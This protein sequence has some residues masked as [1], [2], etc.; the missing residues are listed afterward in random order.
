MPHFTFEQPIKQL[1]KRK[2][3]YYY[4][5]I[6]ADIVGKYE[7]KQATRLQCIIDQKVSFSCGLNH[8]GDGNYFIVATRHVK[9]LSKQENDVVTFE[10][11]EDPNPLGVELP[12]VL[13]VLIN[14]YPDAKKIHD[15]FT[16]GKKRSLIY[17]IKVIKLLIDQRGNC[18]SPPW[19]CCHFK[20][21]H[22]I[23]AWVS[24]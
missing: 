14:Q 5:T 2:G 23:M 1:E 16:D 10:I 4:L 15:S 8:L 11:S 12:E 9:S 21:P 3:G 20:I 17:S 7:K 6:T 13:Q 24:Y 22:I 19:L 18:H